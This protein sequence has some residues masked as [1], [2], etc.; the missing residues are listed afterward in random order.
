M[1][2]SDDIHALDELLVS[3]QISAAEYL[4]RR[5]QLT[6]T[7]V[8]EGARRDTGS[9]EV[10]ADPDPRPTE[11]SDGPAT[12][13]S[14]GQL[15]TDQTPTYGRRGPWLGPL[16]LL[17]VI[18]VGTTVWLMTRSTTQSSAS[19][20]PTSSPA[21]TSETTRLVVG[22]MAGTTDVA[23]YTGPATLAEAQ[24]RGVIGPAEADFL[25]GCGATSGATQV[26]ISP[27][28]SISAS[29]FGCGSPTLATR[30]LSQL[31]AWMTAR[32]LKAVE[33]KT[34]AVM[35]WYTD[36][37]PAEPTRPS[38]LEIRYTSD[39]YLVGIVIQATTKGEALNAATEVLHATNY[40]PSS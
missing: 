25:T 22:S 30:T 7:S 14:G 20:N 29:V 24:T 16:V 17:I 19:P 6:E 26:I 2:P 4:R 40:E 12:Q 34:P 33:L 13:H 11:A 39:S 10:V 37:H 18:A 35:S 38:R 9:R 5:D 3:G 23:Q 15:G 21:S 36:K 28:W 32:D 8:G 1:V 31:P 27:T